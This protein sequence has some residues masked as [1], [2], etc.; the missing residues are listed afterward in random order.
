MAAAWFL[1]DF[2]ARDLRVADGLLAGLVRG[3]RRGLVR[4]ARRP[5]D[6]LHPQRA[7]VVVVG[8]EHHLVALL[9]HV[10]EVLAAL[11]LCKQPA[12]TPCIFNSSKLRTTITR[13]RT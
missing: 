7:L 1:T 11:R 2:H 4:L 13:S 6:G 10:E 3:G 12:T 8:G 5:V 9:H